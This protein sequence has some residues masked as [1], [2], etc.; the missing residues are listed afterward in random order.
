MPLHADTRLGPY[1]IVE[2]L[3]AGGMGEVYRAWDDRL[4]RMVALKVLPADRVGNAERRARFLQEAQLASWLQHPHIVTVHDIGSA[5]SGEYLAMELVQGRTLDAVVPPGGLPLPAALRYGIQIADALAVAHAAGI[6]HRDLKP[7]N[8]MVTDQDQIKILDFGLATLSSRGP[9]V[10]SDATTIAA[11]QVETGAGTILGT[12]AYMSPEQ[13]EGRVVDA[14]SDLFSFGAILY[15]M[16]S[17]VRA[18]R[19][20]S[21]PGTLAAVINL[22]PEPLGSITRHVPRPLEQLVRACLQKQPEQRVQS[23]ADVKTALEGLREASSSGAFRYA[24]PGLAAGWRRL[25]LPLIGVAAVVA[26]GL[27]AYT[28]WPSSVPSVAVTP[29]PLTTLPGSETFPTFS[30]DGTEVAFAWL[31]EGQR[32]Y[33]VYIQAVDAAGT[34]RRLTDDGSAHLYPAW[35]PDGQSLALWHVPVGSTPTTTTTQARLVLVPA[36]GGPERQLLE[37]NGAPRR[38]A[39][40]PDGRWLALSPVG[41]RA[42]RD[43]GIT[44]VSPVTGERVEW[45]AIDR[46]FAASA[47]PA[48]SPD[49]R[50]LAFMRATD[51]YS[52]RVFLA[53]V[54][55]DG[56]PGGTPAALPYGG[57]ETSLPVW[58]ADGRSLLLIEGAPSSNG[59]VVRA[60]I[61]GSRRPQVIT[62]LEHAASIALAPDA[63]RLAFHRPGIDVDIWR[64]DLG[65]PAANGRLA[66]STM[67]EE[68]ADYSPD[69]RQLAFSSNR[70]GAREIWVSDL[71]GERARQLTRFGGPVPGWARWSPDGRQ[72]V[73]DGRPAGDSE[74]FVAAADGSALRQLTTNPAEDARPTWAPDGSIY[75]ASNR[76]G[77]TEIWRM[78]ADGG[79]LTQLTREGGNTVEVSPD[80]AWIYYQGPSA[81]RI[82]HRIRPDGSDDAVVVAED[83]R[84]GMFRPTT[85][86]LWFL[87]NPAPGQATTVLRILGTDGAIR[88]VQTVDFV[89]ISVGLSIAPDGRSVLVTRNDRNGS[90]LLV[91]KGFR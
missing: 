21:T 66:P 3:G 45:T 36:G 11:A 5:A 59:G 84:V 53:A 38:I 33:D 17:G 31:R 40:S 51:D 65:N 14:R 7:G 70:S 83:V 56:R 46:A 60:S 24:R 27:G 4:N 88:D 76:S 81:P 75:F 52:S 23:A 8:I 69:G 54:G 30:P 50:R 78:S 67:W 85:R 6:V 74:I 71:S 82:I 29:A 41:L 57:R 73:F 22:E 34:P 62:G 26:A 2:F 63:E 79:N 91:V 15:E 49:G 64:L 16:L 77:R 61:D 42:N 28:W 19:G 1:R 20:N 32:A 55:A 89:P 87:T 9:M 80:G 25:A 47:D 72:I 90:D 43:R 37:W 18:F 58:S 48:F 68:G 39:W 35:S 13:A 12:V 10:A 86:G 44:L